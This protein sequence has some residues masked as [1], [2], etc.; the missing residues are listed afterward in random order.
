MIVKI[1]GSGC[2]KCQTLEK[3]VRELVE[4]LELN[5]EIVKITDIDEIIEC[6]VMLTPGLIIDDGIVVSGRLPSRDEVESLL[7]SAIT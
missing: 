6:G 4:E 3:I 2:S 5:V 7:R 1:L